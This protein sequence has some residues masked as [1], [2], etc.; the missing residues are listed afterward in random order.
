MSFKR[1]I[2]ICQKLTVNILVES[3][4]IRKLSLNIIELNRISK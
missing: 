1:V 3:K 4:W 2:I